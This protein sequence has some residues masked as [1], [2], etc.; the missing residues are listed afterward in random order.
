MSGINVG[1]A[2]PDPTSPVG[3]FRLMAG[4][5]DFKPL[6]PPVAG[7]GEYEDASDDEIQSYLDATSG[8]L[9]RALGT[10][11]LAMA[12]AAA[13]EAKLIQDYDLRL[14]TVSRAGDLRRVGQAFLAQAESDD[15]VEGG[16]DVFE[17]FTLS[18]NT[19]SIP[20]GSL[21]RV[22]R[23]YHWTTL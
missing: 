6:D 22:G 15:M 17:A 23:E 2:P 5:T 11:F 13:S 10:Y 7:Q 8:N 20:E 9:N 1:I 3:R 19:S 16:T 18:G 12:A 14:S 4:D 21:P